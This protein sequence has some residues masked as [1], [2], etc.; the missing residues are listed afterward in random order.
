MFDLDAFVDDCVAARQESEPHRA[1]KETLTRVV[2]DP[3]ALAAALPP[4][5]A[6][7]IRLH[8][9]PDLTV[10]NVVWAPG[11]SFGPHNH[12]MFAAIAIYTGGEDNTFFRR[13]ETTLVGAGGR[14]LRPRDVCLLGDDAVHAVVN[15][16]SQFTGAIHVYGGDFFTTPRSEWRGDPYQE[17][18]YDVD[19]AIAYFE[20]ANA[21]TRS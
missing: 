13:D 6:G 12:R 16:T 18:A 17:E 19:R 11:M 14:S 9:S 3:S 15:P 1:I 10:L 8:V 5:R 21:D 7:L 2:A 20:A 4:E